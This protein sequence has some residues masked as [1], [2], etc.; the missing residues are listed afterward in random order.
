MKR[1]ERRHLKENEIEILARQAREFVEARRREVTAVGV[2]LA[3][4]GVV[5]LGYMAWH[6]SVQSR[7]HARLAQAMAVEQ[8]R[9]GPAAAPGGATAPT[10]S[11]PTEQARDEAALVQFKA[12]ADTYPSTD[13]G[14]FARY[15]EASILVRLGRPAEA[16]ERYQQVIGLAG[17]GNIYGEM[18]RLG[19]A[20]AHARAGQYDQ[21]IAAFKE[22][23]QRTD[24]SLP[25][26][27]VLMQLGRTYIEAGRQ[28]DAV[29]TLTRLVEQFPDSPYT[30]EARQQLDDLKKT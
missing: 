25:T 8:V 19:L 30:S 18:A 11:F 16:I 26:D 28:A 6:Q 7:A 5:A 13:A 24:G 20:E 17:A 3:L 22:L 29:E 2:A 14:I 21:A 10:A 15:E 27:A 9:V 1:T 23:A 4:L 12:T